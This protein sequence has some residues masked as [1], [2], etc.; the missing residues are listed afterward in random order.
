MCADLPFTAYRAGVG[1]I[2]WSLLLLP[3]SINHI[4]LHSSCDL[5]PALSLQGAYGWLGKYN[6][7]GVLD[8]FAFCVLGFLGCWLKFLM[9]SHNSWIY[10]LS[11]K[12]QIPQELQLNIKGLTKTDSLLTA[13]CF[14]GSFKHIGTHM[15]QCT[16][17]VHLLS[18]SRWVFISSSTPQE[19]PD[20][21]QERAPKSS[22]PTCKTHCPC[23]PRRRVLPLHSLLSKTWIST[24]GRDAK[25]RM[26]ELEMRVAGACLLSD[27]I[28]LH[29]F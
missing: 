29:F 4:D 3:P 9:N 12:C 27:L 10:W 6:D 18:Q 13:M 24:E 8:V 11:R 2:P 17:T 16:N 26:W 5:R 23:P 15:F 22:S 20:S 25:E 14:E 19:I 28:L 21:E 1:W 7:P